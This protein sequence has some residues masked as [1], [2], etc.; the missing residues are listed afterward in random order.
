[1]RSSVIIVTVV[2]LSY[3]LAAVLLDTLSLNANTHFIN[4]GIVAP[5][6]ISGIIFE[7]GVQDLSA[8]LMAAKEIS[9]SNVIL[10]GT[11]FRIAVRSDDPGYFRTT[12]TCDELFFQAFGNETV[13]AVIGT[14]YDSSTG[15]A[16][17]YF[18]DP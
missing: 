17:Q 6:L 13:S 9:E 4:I 1:M 7:E 18:G 8:A 11:G 15:Y 5:R 14:Y 3:E 16:A 10:P 12:R 2:L